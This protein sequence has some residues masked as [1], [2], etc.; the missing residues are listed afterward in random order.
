M[1][2][3]I[4]RCEYYIKNPDELRDLLWTVRAKYP[5][6]IDALR[7]ELNMNHST[8]NS[9]IH[10]RRETYPGNMAKIYQFVKEKLEKVD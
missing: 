3:K 10:N 6:S 4:E 8:L 1:S 2:I 7:K 5:M 9:F